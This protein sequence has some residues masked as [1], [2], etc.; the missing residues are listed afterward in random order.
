MTVPSWYVKSEIPKT[1]IYFLYFMHYTLYNRFAYGM[2]LWY[3]KSEIKKTKQFVILFQSSMF[4][5][6]F[7]P[8]LTQVG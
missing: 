1:L 3:V 2:P 4:Y 6:G 7:V 5:S 8:L